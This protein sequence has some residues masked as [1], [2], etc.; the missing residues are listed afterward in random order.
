MCDSDAIEAS[1]PDA[2]RTHDDVL[3]Q[4][5]RSDLVDLAGWYRAR[6]DLTSMFGCL[7]LYT[8]L[9]HPPPSDCPRTVELGRNVLDAWLA[10]RTPAYR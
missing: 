7:Y 9:R 3:V 4:L 10:A 5:S 2:P 8:A 1:G 6:G